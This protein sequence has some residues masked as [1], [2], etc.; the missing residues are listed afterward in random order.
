MGQSPFLHLALVSVVKTLRCLA[1]HSMSAAG[2]GQHL[3]RNV[4]LRERRAGVIL[5]RAGC[6]CGARW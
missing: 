6:L 5:T 3:P 2:G 4:K 1:A